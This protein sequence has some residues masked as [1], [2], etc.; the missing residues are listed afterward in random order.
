MR[1]AMSRLRDILLLAIGALP[2][3]AGPALA[4]GDAAKGAALFRACGA[5]HSL[6]PD[7]NMT[8][9]SLGGF[10]E[11]KAGSLKSF[12]RYSPALKSSDVVWDEKSLDPWLKSP[13][14]FIPRNRM[15]FPGIPDSRQRADVIAFLKQQ[16]G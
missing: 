5:C 2:V 9:P 10:W 12:E 8:G 4:A 14:G 1:A 7:R 15:I 16:I 13:S 6:Q 3:I 11:R